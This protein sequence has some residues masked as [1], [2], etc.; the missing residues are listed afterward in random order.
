MIPK[1]HDYE[2]H[3]TRHNRTNLILGTILIATQEREISHTENLYY[4]QSLYK[5]YLLLLQS[6]VSS[7]YDSTR[8]EDL[9]D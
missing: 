2:I 4:N 9:T 7:Y 3:P 1:Q 5:L 6:I 8:N